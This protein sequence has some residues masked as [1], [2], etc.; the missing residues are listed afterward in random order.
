MIKNTG[1]CKQKPEVL[2]A[3]PAAF[4]L[5]L[6]PIELSTELSNPNNTNLCNYML[7]CQD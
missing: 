2:L 5:T 7:F 4:G 6:L 1:Y 3:L